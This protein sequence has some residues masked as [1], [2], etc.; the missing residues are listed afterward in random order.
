ML[1][2]SQSKLT[3][4]LRPGEERIKKLE[5]SNEGEN[6][7]FQMKQEVRICKWW[8]CSAAYLDILLILS[9]EKGC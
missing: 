7:E 2:L 8:R 9:V 4:K 5:T 1:E 6:A 3:D